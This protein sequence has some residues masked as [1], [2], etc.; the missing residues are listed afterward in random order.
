[1]EKLETI[2]NQIASNIIQRDYARRSQI[3]VSNINS[4]PHTQRKLLTMQKIKD[5]QDQIRQNKE[6]SS[7]NTK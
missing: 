6:V 5:I 7:S 1:M 2:R 3:N 4:A